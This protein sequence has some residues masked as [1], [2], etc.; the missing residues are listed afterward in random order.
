MVN[1]W[2]KSALVAESETEF[3]TMLRRRLR[4]GAAPV[5]ACAGFDLD[6]ASAYLEGALGG[7]HR[8]GY[9]SHLAGCV[10]CR[11]HLI[12]L[13]RLAQCEPF[14]EVQ[15]VSAPVRI[16]VWGRLKESVASWFDISS[17]GFKW[18]IASATG[19]TFAILIAALG[20]QAWRQASKHSAVTIADKVIPSNQTGSVESVDQQIQSPAPE[21]LPQNGAFADTSSSIPQEP[22]AINSETAQVLTPKPLVG[23]QGNDPKFS[24]EAK[25]QYMS[26]PPSSDQPVEAPVA[27]K[28]MPF[29]AQAGQSS[30]RIEALL[31]GS[32]SEINAQRLGGRPEELAEIVAAAR[33][34]EQKD[35]VDKAPIQE[36][37]VSQRISS[38]LKSVPPDP[39]VR[40]GGISSF[41][42]KEQ[43]TPD[44]ES[45]S[46]WIKYV[47]DQLRKKN[48]I[49]W[50]FGSDS[51]EKP[52]QDKQESSDAESLSPM[53][54][55]F[56]DKVF[57]RK[58]G[59][60]IDKEYNSEMQEWRRRI[61][62]RGSEQYKRV[63]AE[64]P[65]LKAFFEMGPILIV[66]K[67]RIYK[68]Q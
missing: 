67:N 6:A 23:P 61:L 15:P 34:E 14:A 1:E 58:N 9:E 37:I 35:V 60:W 16:P 43:A 4:S 65:Q 21:S 54:Y 40:N 66:W 62:T 2:N 44:A 3:E 18:R 59:V 20:V 57:V 10:T 56:R 22:A 41:V 28:P 68:V 26:L 24:V 17:L 12:E 50:P 19:A 55:P 5:A 47:K 32:P 63:L 46:S 7:S 8:A 52:I 29:V 48:P 11:H 49:K 33:R 30:Q 45:R 53:E 13:A 42:S 51:D 31:M 64:E 27:P 25:N 38:R 36:T 39:V